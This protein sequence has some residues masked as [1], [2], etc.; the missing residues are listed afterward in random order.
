MNKIKLT[1]LLVF[2]LLNTLPGFCQKRTSTLKTTH[3][4]V[5][6]E[7]N[8]QDIVSTGPVCPYDSTIFSCNLTAA[9]YQWQIDTGAGFINLADNFNYAGTKSNQIKLSNLQ[10][11][12]AGYRYRCFAGASFGDTSILKF[13]TTWTGSFSSE[14]ENPLNW[15]CGTVPGSSSNVL[16]NGG[17][18]IL[19]SNAVVRSITIKPSATFT[20]ATGYNLILSANAVPEAAGLAHSLPEQEGIASLAIQQFAEAADKSINAPHSFIL[21]RHGKIIADAWWNPYR[22]GLRR[23]LY[24]NTKTFTSTAIGFAIQENLLALT[25]K[26]I[27]FF[28]DQ[29]PANPSLKLQH[30]TIKDVLI[31]ADG[32]YP[33]PTPK[34]A[35]DSN[36][37]KAF[38]TTPVIY[39]PGSRFFYNS[40]GSCML[41]AIIQKV[42]GKT[43]MD[44]LTPRLFNPLNIEGMDWEQDTKGT[45]TGGWGL[46][47]KTEDMAKFG[48]LWLNK[49]KW[50][51][52]QVLPSGWSDEA[53]AGKILED[54]SATQAQ[55]D[56]SD[57][58]QGYGYQI[59]RCRH[60]SYMANGSY[61]QLTVVMPDQDAVLAITA[62][63]NDTQDELNLI[64]NYLLPAFT[65][66]PL[67]DN[68]PAQA[69]LYTR[70][71]S[72]GVPLAPKNNI[73][74]AQNP[75]GKT[76]AFG[77]NTGGFNSITFSVK[78]DTC[79]VNLITSKGAY[80]LSFGE[81]K[82]IEGS[83]GKTGP[84]LTE[85]AL[86]NTA[87]LYPAK[88]TGSYTW[89]DS[90]TLQLV[91]RYLETPHAETYT[92]H[93]NNS[94]LL[95]DVEQSLDFGANKKTYPAT[96]Q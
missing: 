78:T 29:V 27:S 31:M 58:L 84:S 66:A 45:N 15:S 8:T 26:V 64:W 69:N 95:M 92:F 5:L 43:L 93:F 47:I 87:F 94:N 72:L 2:T 91:L 76:F 35:T 19:H 3:P 68:K 51:G 13:V 49:G 40:L 82:W 20:V 36:W 18:V 89:K 32:Q 96:L 14:W 77:G 71:K 90:V 41:S 73:V 48:Q 67:P 25:D 81:G 50:Q 63:T 12:F 30:L 9:T 24:S 62:E 22:P 86:E 80:P 17:I 83:T 34:I 56:A 60:N 16:I 11:T 54:S 21:M 70:L 79:S 7:A 59:W 75:N 53:S 6:K 33:D 57:W 37:V 88:I 1:L 55:K 74:P 4:V 61:G 10:P 85:A 38:L 39:E 44:Y 28:P 42:T 46:R 65:N 23:A 52:R